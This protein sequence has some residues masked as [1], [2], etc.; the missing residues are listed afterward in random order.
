[1]AGPCAWQER[2]TYCDNSHD[3]KHNKKWGPINL[4][5]GSKSLKF[6]KD[7]SNQDGHNAADKERR[8]FEHV[9]DC[10]F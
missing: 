10:Q 3:K 5:R 9:G 2:N 7:A 1:M 8:S 6:P 4:I